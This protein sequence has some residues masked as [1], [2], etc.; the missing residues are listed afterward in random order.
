MSCIMENSRIGHAA[1]SVRPT[2]ATGGARPMPM[3][4]LADTLRRDLVLCD[5]PHADKPSVLK[6]LAREV[7]ARLSAVDEAALLDPGVGS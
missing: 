5:L 3:L 1:F 4:S 7:S 6:A 2:N